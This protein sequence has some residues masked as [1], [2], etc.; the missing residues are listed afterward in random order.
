[1]I[2]FQDVEYLYEK[3]SRHEV[4]TEDLTTAANA[5]QLFATLLKDV[6]TVNRDVPDAID[7][8]GAAYQSAALHSTL[9]MLLKQ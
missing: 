6:G 1:V 5:L 7:N 9:E 4:L 2:T 8:D 3:L